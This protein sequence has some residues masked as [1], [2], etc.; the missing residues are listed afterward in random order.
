MPV[1][2]REPCGQGR[3]AGHRLHTG[4]GVELYKKESVRQLKALLGDLAAGFP[5]ELK[6]LTIVVQKGV[7]ERLLKADGGTDE[8]AAEAVNIL[9]A[10]LGWK[11]PL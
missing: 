2:R 11:P 1:L 7:Q 8:C 5:R 6:V 4:R 10:G 3:A 9:A